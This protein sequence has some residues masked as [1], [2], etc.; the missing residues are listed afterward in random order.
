MTTLETT[1][2]VQDDHRMVLQLPDEVSPGEHRVRVEIDPVLEADQAQDETTP[3]AWD[4]DVL[5]YGGEGVFKGDI[6][7]FIEQE[8]EGRMRQISGGMLP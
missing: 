3:V 2:I 5:V 1:A 6:Q 7:Q 8:R 4:G